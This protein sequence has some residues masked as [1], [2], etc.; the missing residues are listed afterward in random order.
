[1]SSE[2]VKKWN[3]VA[4]Q[5]KAQFGKRP[6]LDAVLFLIGMRELGIAKSEFTKEEKVDLIHIATCRILSLSGYY[7]LEGQDPDGWP[8]WKKVKELPY[9]DIFQQ[10][11]FLKQHVI[12]YFEQENLIEN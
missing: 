3:V 11:V 4:N 8:H 9:V 10:E 2:I 5:L 1:M 12:E 7:E 6:K